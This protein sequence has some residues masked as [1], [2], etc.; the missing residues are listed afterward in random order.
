MLYD[1][2]IKSI[3]PSDW[4]IHRIL[5]SDW[6]TVSRRMILDSGAASH[7]PAAVQKVSGS[8][9]KLNNFTVSKYSCTKLLQL[10]IIQ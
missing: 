3:L 9:F 5:V 6:S 2:R 10:N 7:N 1:C 4:L 8:L